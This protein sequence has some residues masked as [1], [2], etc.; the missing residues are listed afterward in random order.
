MRMAVLGLAAALAVGACGAVETPWEVSPDPA[1]HA[2]VIEA[3]GPYGA[4]TLVALPEYVVTDAI[5]SPGRTLDRAIR[6][7]D[8][9]W[10]VAGMAGGPMSMVAF[11]VR[12]GQPPR[13][14]GSEWGDPEAIAAAAGLVG[15]G[16]RVVSAW[17]HHAILGERDGEIV[18]VP[19]GA[20]P[21]AQDPVPIA[22]YSERLRGMSRGG[23]L[24]ID[25]AGGVAMI[26][27]FALGAAFPLLVLLGRTFRARRR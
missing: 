24:G 22:E 19:L 21:I 8:T 25:P 9:W 26:S 3:A 6:A 12:D 17:G 18:A 11:T 14:A 15:R 23:G 4:E 5:D 2:A 10:V 7:T 16:A 13:L 1:V 27:L 20:E